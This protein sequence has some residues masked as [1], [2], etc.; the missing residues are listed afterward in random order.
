MSEK[1]VS[2][3]P[4]SP[5]IE[6]SVFRSTIS[7]LKSNANCQSEDMNERNGS[8][9]L[10]SPRQRASV[11]SI[12]EK[13]TSK[14]RRRVSR[15]N[16]DASAN[17]EKDRKLLEVRVRRQG[18][19]QV[20]TLLALVIFVIVFFSAMARREHDL[21]LQLNPE[22]DETSLR[23]WLEMPLNYDNRELYHQLVRKERQKEH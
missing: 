6:H 11:F 20:P 4:S 7:Q 12:L 2:I 19:W 23:T 13:C 22:L 16:L 14:H 9:L 18:V 17:A 1:N 5:T 8:L 3:Q 15:G 10:P 21:M